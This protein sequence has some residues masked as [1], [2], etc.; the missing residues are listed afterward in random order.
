MKMD[1][2][3]N[4]EYFRISAVRDWKTAQGLFKIKRY[5][6]CLFFCHLTL[7]KA[8]KYLVTVK[9]NIV[10]P[11]SHDLP[12]LAKLAK[13][14]IDKEQRELLADVTQF[15]ISS[16]YEN[17]KMNFY[18]QCTLEYTEKYLNITENLFLWLK[19]NY[20]RK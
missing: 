6:A 18:K 17:Q 15:N 7:E 1:L 3:K 5:D 11:Y 19:K 13:L 4:A 10:P 16:R 20:P 12:R 14:K 8:L 9:V 2:S